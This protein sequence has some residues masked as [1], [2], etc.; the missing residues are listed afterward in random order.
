MDVFKEN[1]LFLVASFAFITILTTAAPSLVYAQGNPFG[2]G[3]GYSPGESQS[4]N[5]TPN[6][7]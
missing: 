2:V 3:G 4:N 1:K 5:N 6:T 7:F